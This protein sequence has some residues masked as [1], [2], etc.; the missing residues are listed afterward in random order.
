MTAIRATTVDRHM[1]A[2]PPCKHQPPNRPLPRAP[3]F[4][5]RLEVLGIDLAGALAVVARARHI[6]LVDAGIEPAHLVGAQAHIHRAQVVHQVLDAGGAGNRQDVRVLVQQ[7]GQRE[8]GHAATHFIGD[9]TVGRQQLQVG[10]VVA[11]RKARHG[12]AD[13]LLVQLGHIGQVAAQEAARDRA[14]GNEADTELAA[15]VEH[16]DLGV[17]RPERI[18]GLQRRDRVHCVGLSQRVGRNL[19]QAD[20]ADLAR[21][22]QVAQRAHAVLDRHRFVPA[23]QVVEVDHVGVEAL[24]RFLAGRAN[25]LGAAV[26]HAHLLAVALEVDAGHAALAREREA[27]AVLGQHAADQALVG[28][29]AVQRGGVEMGHAGVERGQQE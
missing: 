15:G 17:A 8:L 20:G 21:A 2:A 3:P 24:E 1:R 10:R 26:D 6:A 14:E 12:A 7:P 16:R 19:G 5:D 11:G 29:E 13:V 9:R 23:V 4:S 25:G 28:A 22:H 18:L 27:A